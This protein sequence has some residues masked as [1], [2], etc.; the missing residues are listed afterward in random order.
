MIIKL[1]LFINGNCIILHHQLTQLRKFFNMQSFEVFELAKFD[2]QFF[3]CV[4]INLL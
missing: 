2:Y 4:V 3:P 1:R